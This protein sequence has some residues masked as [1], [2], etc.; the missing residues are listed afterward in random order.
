[1]LARPKRVGFGVR[2]DLFLRGQR[3]SIAKK[4]PRHEIKN[5]SLARRAK[6]KQSLKSLKNKKEA[7]TKKGMKRRRWVEQ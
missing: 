3:G 7:G 1:L 5:T 4:Q 2:Q 6:L